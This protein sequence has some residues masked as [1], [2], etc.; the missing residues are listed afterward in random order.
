[1]PVLTEFP[2]GGGLNEHISKRMLPDGLLSYCENFRP[3]LRGELVTRPG[4]TALSMDAL[5]LG[6]FVAL[7]IVSY[8][9]QLVAVG[10]ASNGTTSG[11]RELYTYH[12]ESSSWAW[13]GVLGS[14]L[15]LAYN[16]VSDL[17]EIWQ[18]PVGV[19]ATQVDLAYANGYVLCAYHNRDNNLAH[20]HIFTEDGRPVLAQDFTSVDGVRCVGVG[21]ILVLVTLTT[22]GALLARTFDTASDETF[23][24]TTSLATGVQLAALGGAWDVAPQTGGTTDWLIAYRS[25]TVG[26]EVQWQQRTSA[27]AQV[28]STVTI[29]DSTAAHV[30][31][32]SHNNE[33]TNVI[34][35]NESTGNYVLRSYTE[36]TRALLTGPTTIVVTSCDRQALLA[37]KSSSAIH[38]AIR[39]TDT[40]RGKVSY[41]ER[42]TAAHTV[43]AAS[44]CNEVDVTGK[45]FDFDGDA[46][47][48]YVGAPGLSYFE[49][50]DALFASGT[51]VGIQP[52]PHVHGYSDHGL[53]AGGPLLTTNLE[54]A[55]STPTDGA[56]KF[57]WCVLRSEATTIGTNT[58]RGVPVVL[59]FNAGSNERRQFAEFAGLLYHAGGLLS[60]FDGRENV[61]GG[62]PTPEITV[63]ST[64]GGSLTPGVGTAATLT[65]FPVTPPAVVLNGLSVLLSVDGGGFQTVTFDAG[66]IDATAIAAQINAATTGLTATVDG[67]TVVITSD[68]TGPSSQLIITTGDALAVS[69]L[70]FFAGQ[71]ANGEATTTRY[72][73]RSCHVWKDLKG[74]THRSAPSPI[75]ETLLATG[76]NRIDVVTQSAHTVRRNDI[77]DDSGSLVQ[78]EIYR[79]RADQTVFHLVHTIDNDGNYAA[80]ETFNDIVADSDIAD[81]QVL[82]TQSVTPEENVPGP[83]CRFIAAGNERMCLMGLADPYAYQFTKLILPEEPCNTPHPSRASYRGRLHEPITAGV[84]DDSRWVLFTKRRPYQIAGEGPG[85]TGQGAFYTAKAID[86]AP[87]GAIDWKGVLRTP[88]GVMFQLAPDKIYALRGTSLV[89]AG[90]AAQQTLAAYPNIAASVYIRAQQLAVFACNNDAGDDGVIL[91]CD[92]SKEGEQWYVD[93]V[94]APVTALAEHL[95]RI[96]YVAA[97]VVWLQDEAAGSGAHV[98]CLAQFGRF[99]FDTSMGYGALTGLGVLGENLGG[100]YSL[101]EEISYN[102]GVTWDEI[103]RLDI[104]PATHAV[105]ATV[106]LLKAPPLQRLEGYM[107]RFRTADGDPNSAGIKLNA[108]VTE[109]QKAYGLA[110]RGSD[111]TQ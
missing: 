66:D 24:G 89:W 50:D 81:N 21:N 69:A 82:Y 80:T 71:T 57:F 38:V 87:G 33:T 70:G 26:Q 53:A 109:T 93:D 29:S 39:G 88:R 48:S 9:D 41:S 74:N 92:Q 100:T 104:T 65:T 2:F 96:A 14:L 77:T 91:I 44:T 15:G 17:T 13:R 76:E 43:S 108:L 40:L 106:E 45:L 97:G 98:D 42:T 11:A 55:C 35:R 58:D 36:S 4:Y 19:R 101:L 79:T 18:A 78:T 84:W 60:V 64:S 1:M 3:G 90:E 111:V 27:L 8:A 54:F 86:D 20:V 6:T 103:G 51:L 83:A 62:F 107:L 105:G 99:R 72:R 34:Y 47:G 23:S 22:G 75:R 59:S 46:F 25:A 52:T 49:G 110:R 16:P 10:R 5:S 63:S 61:E 94:G 28:G 32:Q 67:A 56:G 12:G 85:A 37:R 102:D 68:T 7:D 31:I 95:G 73:H 30:S